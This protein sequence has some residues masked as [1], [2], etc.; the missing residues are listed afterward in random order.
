MI[1]PSMKLNQ[2]HNELLN[3]K[4]KV[5][6][7][8][9]KIRPKAIKF[10]RKAQIFPARYVDEYIIP[11]TKDKFVIVFHAANRFEVERPYYSTFF[12]VY[13]GNERFVLRGISMG[14][15]HTPNSEMVMLPQIH[16][17]TSHFF[18]RY[19]ER[20]LHNDKLSANEVA[21]IFFVR[22]HDIIPIDNNKVINRNY[23][24]YSFNENG[25]RV[26]D[27]FCFAETGIE[28]TFNEY[29]REDDVVDA[30]IIKFKTFLSK[31]DLTDTQAIAIDDEHMK[32]L[33]RCVDEAKN[34]F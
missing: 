21:G 6:Y 3:N 18:K 8:I 25:Y 32:T 34:T 27:G 26:F 33:S 7:R 10:L 31:N 28:G 5:Q 1:V 19:N 17:F 22:N 11:S 24:E 13:G 16:V 9:D 20:F 23:E 12:I 14:Y 29:N 4:E 2:M 30:M 15:K